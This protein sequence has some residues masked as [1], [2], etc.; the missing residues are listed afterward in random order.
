MNNHEVYTKIT[1][2][3]MAAIN[4]GIV[5]WTKPYVG[6]GLPRNASSG[7]RYSGINVWATMWEGIF[8]DYTS[9]GWVTF[10]QALDLKLCVNKGQ[11]A[12]P[13]LFM[14]KVNPKRKDGAPTE[15]LR[16]YFIARAYSVFN[17]DQLKELEPGALAKVRADTDVEF[18]HDPVEACEAM[19]TKTGAVIKHR[20]GNPVVEAIPCYLPEGD[21][22]EMPFRNKFVSAPRY[23]AT[24]FHELIHWTGAKH[25]LN[26]DLIT[27][28]GN[29]QYAAEELVAELGAAFLAHRF[30]FDVVTYSAQYMSGWL[31]AMRENPSF[32]V[33]CASAASTAAEY[34][35]PSAPAVD[36]DVEEAQTD[37]TTLARSRRTA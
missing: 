3:I 22:I 25:R 2:R 34:L 26:R 35:Y 15:E 33:A 11:K 36:D 27:R 9:C 19:V 16:P 37:V 5:P 4:Q 7:R 20:R 6:A 29:P 28:F 14:S 10:K 24:L 30:G 17:L 32:L 18:A 31:D 1:A 13:I 12:T 21:F 23:Y 8:N